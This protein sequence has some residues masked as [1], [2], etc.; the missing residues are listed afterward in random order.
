MNGMIVPSVSAGS[1][2]RAARDAWTPQVMTPSG[3]ASSGPAGAM[4][5]HASARAAARLREG[6]AVEPGRILA[7]DLAPLFPWDS[8]EVALDD[9]PRMRPGRHGVRIVRGPHDV[10]DPDELAARDPHAIVDERREDLAPEVFAGREL[11]RGRI[12]IAIFV[13][14]LIE[15]LQEERD[16]AHLV[17]G[18]DELE[19]RES[20]EHAGEDQHDERPLDFVTE[21]GRAEIAVQGLLDR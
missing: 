18:G 19:I 2:Q 1:S 17:L 9:L 7:D 6:K 10:L 8:L 21:H 4:R 16:P 3:A 15:L 20:L 14:R 12:E 11:Q 13:L 5:R